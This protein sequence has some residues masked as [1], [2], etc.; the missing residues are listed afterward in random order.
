[1]LAVCR[2]NIV[3]QAN[4]FSAIWLQKL[5]KLNE[6]FWQSV[7]DE[8]YSGCPFIIFDFAVNNSVWLPSLGL[9]GVAKYW[10]V[11]E[12]AVTVW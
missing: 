6:L 5:P 4:F 11:S 8:C 2:P 7:V 9:S 12:P 3:W 1:M 10:M